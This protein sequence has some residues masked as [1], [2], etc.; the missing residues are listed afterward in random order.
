MHVTGAVKSIPNKTSVA[1]TMVRANGIRTSG[2]R[3]TR[4]C[5][6]VTFV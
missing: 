4:A 3:M 2:I 6:K 5:V 1:I